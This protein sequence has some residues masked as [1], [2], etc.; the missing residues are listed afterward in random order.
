MSQVNPQNN[1]P[2]GIRWGWIVA[3]LAV[4]AIVA[5]LLVKGME[6]GVQYYMTVSEYVG[7]EAKYEGKKIKLAGKVAAGSLKSNQDR[8]EFVVEDLGKSISVLYVG[9][10]PDTFKEGVEVVVEGRAQ[11]EPVFQAQNLMA[12]CASKYEAGGLPPLE[13]MRGKSIY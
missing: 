8:H 7:H 11:S 2:Q 12:K 6:G 3:G 1:R 5:G 4:V 10:V 9:L 13:K